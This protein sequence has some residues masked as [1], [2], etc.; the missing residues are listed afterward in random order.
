[1]TTVNEVKT[2]TTKKQGVK[3]LQ[4]I[5]KDANGNEI[6]A[7][8][9]VQKITVTKNAKTEKILIAENVAFDKNGKLH[10]SEGAKLEV[11]K[12]SI[13]YVDTYKEGISTETVKETKKATVLNIKE[14]RN[15]LAAILRD[16]KKDC[17]D[18][19]KPYML[20]FKATKFNLNN[21]HVHNLTDFLTPSQAIKRTEC[22]KNGTI[23]K[24]TEGQVIE[25][26]TKYYKSLL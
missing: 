16:I 3:K 12:V 5:G 21:V 9:S 6:K 25:L 4:T 22:L 15:S 14:R 23:Q 18:L 7:K 19:I 1:M 17:P 20:M 2:P 10:L 8:K 26:L 13:K 11:T 24:F